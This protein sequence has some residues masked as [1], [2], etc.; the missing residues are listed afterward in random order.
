MAHSRQL[1]RQEEELIVVGQLRFSTSAVGD[2]ERRPEAW[3]FVC[4]ITDEISALARPQRPNSP[5]M[6][7]PRVWVGLVRDY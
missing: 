6:T 1:E 5:E 7:I 3:M 4:E 2:C